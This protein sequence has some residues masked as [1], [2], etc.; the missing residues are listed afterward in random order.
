M[1]TVGPWTLSAQCI[2]TG[3]PS[4]PAPFAIFAEGPGSADITYTSQLNTEPPLVGAT[5]AELSEE[6][7]I[8]SIGVKSPAQDRITGTMI[9]SAEPSDPV[10]TVPFTILS[11]AGARRCRFAGN[12]VP[13]G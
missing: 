9:L 8:F 1:G 12:A 13:A 7:R 4:V 11:D 6:E 2:D 3:S 5:H 10:V